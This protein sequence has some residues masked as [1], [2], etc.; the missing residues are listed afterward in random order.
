MEKDC[1]A[2]YLSDK[3]YSDG[4]KL[5]SIL[6][7]YFPEIKFKIKIDTTERQWMCFKSMLINDKVERVYVIGD[8]NRKIK[9]FY[10]FLKGHEVNKKPFYRAI[11]AWNIEKTHAVFEYDK[12]EVIILETT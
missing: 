11:S 8:K 9:D 2:Y 10:D 12:L 4:G 6:K 5:F 3:T 1:M 7:S